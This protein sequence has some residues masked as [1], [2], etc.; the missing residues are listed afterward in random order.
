M[1]NDLAK[2]KRLVCVN[3]GKIVNPN[4]LICDACG[5]DYN[6]KP[7]CDHLYEKYFVE[8]NPLNLTIELSLKC[9]RCGEITTLICKERMFDDLFKR[10]W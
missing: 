3:C 8:R 4:T 5:T 1:N 7:K 6:D 9:G 10:L 2:H